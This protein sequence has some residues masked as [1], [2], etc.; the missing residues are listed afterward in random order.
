[1]NNCD[2][3]IKETINYQDIH[4]QCKESFGHIWLKDM[5][6][7]LVIL[8]YSSQIDCK[9]I[10]LSCNDAGNVDFINFT[11]HIKTESPLNY[12]IENET[13]GIIGKFSQN[14]EIKS[15]KCIYTLRLKA[16]QN[17]APKMS[18]RGSNSEEKR[19]MTSYTNELIF[20]DDSLEQSSF[21]VDLHKTELSLCD[22]IKFER[23]VEIPQRSTIFHPYFKCHIDGTNIY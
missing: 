16:S 19:N 15:E 6:A 18:A 13:D 21:R 11:S 8:S 2:D 20:D 14:L 17:L 4:E 7:L 3:L 23:K 9:E 12:K 10:I 22:D 5:L 1:M